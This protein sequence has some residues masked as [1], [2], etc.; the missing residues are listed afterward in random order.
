MSSGGFGGGTFVSTSFSS[1]G[2]GG[3]GRSRTVQTQ[4][5]NGQQTTVIREVDEYGNETVTTQTSD[6]RQ[7][8]TYGGGDGAAA[9]STARRIHF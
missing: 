1:S 2:G 7:F 5:V 9:S 4:I 3:F 6:G 8:V